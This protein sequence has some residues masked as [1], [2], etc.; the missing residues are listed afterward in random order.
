MAKIKNLG[1][2]QAVVS[3]PQVNVSSSLFGLSEKA[4]YQP[5]NSRIIAGKRYCAPAIGAK[6]EALSQ[7]PA[8]KL[9]ATVREIGKI[10]PQ[11]ITGVLV[12]YCVSQDHRFVAMQVFHY[13]DFRYNPASEVMFWEGPDAVTVAEMF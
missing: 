8:D 9:L 13:G 3:H 1:M 4:I 2:A 12:E 6:L 7:C 11:E 5:T 10:V